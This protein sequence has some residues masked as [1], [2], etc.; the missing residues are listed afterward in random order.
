MDKDK[1]MLDQVDDLRWVVVK[2]NGVIIQK[3][4]GWPKETYTL[5]EYDYED[6]R[7]WDK[8]DL[9]DPNSWYNTDRIGKFGPEAIERANRCRGCL[10]LNSCTRIDNRT[11]EYIKGKEQFECLVSNA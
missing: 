8:E 11:L 5:E 10:K 1:E 6:P 9:E 2:K 4:Y 3:W 7:G